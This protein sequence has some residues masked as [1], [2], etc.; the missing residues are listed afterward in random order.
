MGLREQVP[1]RWV[2]D[3]SVAEI[4]DHLIRPSR[5]RFLQG[6]LALGGAAVAGPLLLRQSA[7]AAGA[8]PA[9]AHLAFG[10]DPRHDMSVVWSTP[11][12]VDHPRL[13]FGLADGSGTVVA[14]E[15]RA[16]PFNLLDPALVDGSQYH[17]VRLTGL[18]PGTTYGYRLAHDG[19]SSEVRPF[20]TAPATPSRFTFTAFG[21]Q[22]ASEAGAAVTRQVALAR[23]AFNL[24][25]GDLCYANDVGTTTPL[26]LLDLDPTTWDRWFAQAQASAAGVPWMPAL[27]N[28]DVEAGFGPLGYD[29]HLARLALPRNG[30]NDHVYSFLYGNVAFVCADA[31]DISPETPHPYSG[32]Q[33]TSWLDGELGRLR[34]D[35]TVDFIVVYFH[36]CAFSTITSHGSDGGVRRQW[37]P[38]F[39]RHGVDL[40]I[41]GHNH[42]YERTTPIR[43]GVPTVEAPRGATVRPKADGTTYICAGGGGRSPNTLGPT[44]QGFVS[45]GP[46]A[47]DLVLTGE[48]EAAPWSVKAV[49]NNSF[50]RVEVDPAAAGG[51]TTMSITAIDRDGRPFDAVVLTRPRLVAT[52]PVELPT[53]AP[54]SRATTPAPARRSSATLPDGP[55]TLPKTGGTT[56]PLAPTLALAAG[57]AGLALARRTRGAAETTPGPSSDGIGPVV[58]R[59]ER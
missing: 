28:H 11:G 59:R 38:L 26:D 50:L 49:A 36:H 18:R 20:T 2:R 35:A 25:A 10:N 51:Q 54:T 6:A 4:H 53:V 44:G 55:R 46:A 45:D 48:P 24:V 31:N 16:I 52:P 5:R 37:T 33:Q 27:G 42:G 17:Q 12:P 56:H 40:V 29:G 57:A 7:R 19:A 15:T 13:S 30:F 32:G 22:G 43:A 1:E 8:P 47:H 3:M 9:G 41:N 14:A 34:A 23:P 21:D 58:A 39:D